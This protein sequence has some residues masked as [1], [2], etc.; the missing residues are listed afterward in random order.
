MFELYWKDGLRKTHIE[1]LWARI[2]LQGSIKSLMNI[3]KIFID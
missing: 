2:G 3:F 1:Y